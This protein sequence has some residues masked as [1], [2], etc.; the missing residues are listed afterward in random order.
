M[1]WD[2]AAMPTLMSNTGGKP[3]PEQATGPAP[4]GASVFQYERH[5]ARVVV[6][7]GS[8]DM[9]SITPLAEALRAAAGER[10]KVVLDASGV[11]FADS[12]FLNLLILTHRAGTLRLVAPSRQ[13]RLLCEVTGVDAVLD[14][15]ET[16]DDAAV[17]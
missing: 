5:G 4:E 9:H 1:P 3:P 16:V 10:P 8:Y 12:S 11:T 13:V 14:I 15:R 7:Q 6:A 2:E 17:R